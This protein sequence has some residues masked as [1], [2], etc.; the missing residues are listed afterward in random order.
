MHVLR[1]GVKM[2]VGKEVCLD[3]VT[4]PPSFDLFFYLIARSMRRSQQTQKVLDAMAMKDLEEL[5]RL[6]RQP[7]G[8]V[9][10]KIR[11]YVWYAVRKNKIL[12]S[13]SKKA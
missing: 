13:K 6:A 7:E 2:S 1:M 9:D 8:F 10:D 3:Y 12:L 11:Q 5:R 4:L